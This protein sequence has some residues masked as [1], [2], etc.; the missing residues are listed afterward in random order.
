MRKAKWISV[1]LIIAFIFLTITLTTYGIQDVK[2]KVEDGIQVIYNPKK[3]SPLPGTPNEI[4]LT[5]DLCIGNEE[6][7]E[8][9]VFSQIRSVQVDDDGN[10]YAL[11]SKEV[12]VKVFDRNGT[13]L[14][15]F[16]QKGQGPGELQNPIRMHFAPEDKLLIYDSGNNRIS[17]FTLDGKCVKEIP[18]GKERFSRTIP[19]SKGNIIV[20]S[21]SFGDTTVQE[22]KKLDQDLNTIFSIKAAETERLTTTLNLLAPGLMVRVLENDNI[23]WGY[24]LKYEIFVVDSEG[25]TI[26]KIVKD[27]DP[28][29]IS[30]EEK[31]RLKKETLGDR[32]LPP[33]FK[34]SFPKNYYPFYFIICGD[35]GKIYVRTYEKDKKG[36]FIYDVFNPEGRFIARFSLP[37]IDFLYIVKKNKMYTM[38]WEDEKGIPVVKRYDVVWK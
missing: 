25:K 22:I 21:V 23:I 31:D 3:P 24:S 33:G 29:K 34:I 27:Y 7:I 10:I 1:K 9:F 2:I 32:V 36:Q 11:D 17:Y 38:V 15:T 4:V 8:D 5:Q 37:D 26:Q 20:Q 13:H 12:C 28:I 14:R 19:D 16:G 18:A 6:G 35:D 30:K